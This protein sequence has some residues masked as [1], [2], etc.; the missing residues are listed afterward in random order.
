MYLF[1]TCV[2]YHLKALVLLKGFYSQ[3]KHYHLGNVQHE[4][5]NTQKLTPCF[6]DHM[7]S[8]KV[9]QFSNW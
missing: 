1:P 8:L 2:I 5:H 7:C 9:K 6:E 3:F 4:I